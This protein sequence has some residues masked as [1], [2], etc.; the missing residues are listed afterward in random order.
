MLKLSMGLCQM[1][2]I[3]LKSSGVRIQPGLESDIV[4]IEMAIAT[5]K[6]T[7]ARRQL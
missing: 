1:L 6:F 5:L 3:V 4:S 7:A 2:V